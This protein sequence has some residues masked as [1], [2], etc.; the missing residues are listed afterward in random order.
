MY[1][2]RFI[3]FVDILGFG[4]LVEK[5]EVTPDLPKKILDALVSM[6]PTQIQSELVTTVNVELIPPKE[7]EGVR[8]IARMASA[9]QQKMHPV[10]INYFSDSLVISARANDVIASQMVMDLLTKISALMWMSHKLLLR[11]GITVGKLIHVEGGPMF[12]PAMNRAYYLES[13]LADHPRFL[14]DKHCIEQ[15]RKVETFRLFESFIQQDGDFY[16]ASLATSF[17]HILNDSSLVLS[18]EKVLRKFRESM[19]A[20]PAEVE[21]L[22]ELYKE[23]ERVGPKYDWLA[24]EFAARI[25]EV[26]RAY[27]YEDDAK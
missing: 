25:P 11:G 26:E 13:K 12:G 23:D 1:E 6:H 27:P 4:K 20:A 22:R 2:E 24:H 14:I 21:S 15:Y 8:N 16:Y 5:S 19:L 10:H 7:L 3:A 9:A 18:G 17:K